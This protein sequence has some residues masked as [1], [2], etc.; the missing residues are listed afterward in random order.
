MMFWWTPAPRWWYTPEQLAK[1]A[2]ASEVERE[3][4]RDLGAPTLRTAGLARERELGPGTLLVFGDRYSGFPS[5]FWNRSFT[6]R[7]EYLRSGPDFLARAAR[8]GATWVYVL[9]PGIAVQ[10]R[11]PGSGWQEVGPLN[12]INGG[13]TVF[14]RVPVTTPAKAGPAPASPARPVIIYPPVL[15]PPG[16]IGPMP[17]PQAPKPTPAPVAPPRP[18]PAVAPKP[19]PAAAPTKPTPA[20]TPAP[21]RERIFVP[22]KWNEIGTS[23]RPARRRAASQA[24]LLLGVEEQKAAAA[25]ADQLAP[26]GAVV[27]GELVPAVDLGVGFL[28]IRLERCFLNCQCSCMS[29]PKVLSSPVSIASRLL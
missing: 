22:S 27:E 24:P 7:V 19:A 15:G 18:T 3:V 17:L 25:R 14:R 21:A 12:A 6:N 28:I 20:A 11:A 16:A 26:D 9:E 23:T 8:A 10:A 29:L 13:G 5:I 4:D 2:K 1:L